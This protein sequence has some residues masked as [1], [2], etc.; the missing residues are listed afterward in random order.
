MPT[1]SCLRT[2]LSLL[3]AAVLAAGMTQPAGAA[4]TAQWED[5]AGADV[6]AELTAGTYIVTFVEEPAATY[7][8]SM[9]GYS[10]TAPAE[11]NQL[12][13]NAPAVKKYMRWLESRNKST[14][15]EVGARPDDVHSV[16]LNGATVD[17]TARQA[18]ELAKDPRVRAM[19]KNRLVTLDTDESPAALGLPALW[20]DL[21]GRSNAG[22][23]EVVGVLDSGI[24]P[25]SQ[26]FSPNSTPIPN[27]FTGTCQTGEQFTVADCNGKIVGARYYVEGFGKDNVADED[28]LSPRDGDGHGTHTASTAAG[29]TVRNVYVDD[30]RFG[31]ISGVAPGAKIAAYK[32]CWEG[33][34]GVAATGCATADI[35]NALNDAVG[36]GV[37]VINMSIGG[38][39]ESP[40]SDAWEIASL[41]AASAGV[42]V[43]TSAGNSGPGASTLD[44]PS[45]WVTTVAASTHKVNEQVLELADGR[46]FVG[47]S[48]TGPL[49]KLTGMVLAEDAAADDKEQAKLCLPDSLDP[50]LTRGKLVVCIR[51]QNPR[52]EKSLT[53]RKAGGVGMA[54]INPSA[55]S[56]N[57]DM[58]YVPSVHLP[59]SAYE[60]VTEYVTTS[61]QPRGRIVPLN[62]GESKTQTPEV[63]EFSSRGPSTTTGGDILKPDLSAPGVDV[64]AAVTPFNHEGRNYDLQSGTS[65]SAPHVAGVAAL[66][67]QAQPTWSPMMTKSAM[68]TTAR[69]HVSTADPFAQGAGFIR[70][71][72]ATDPGLVFDHGI[73]N[74]VGYLKGEGLLP[75]DS[76]TT[77]E[78]IDGSELNQASIAV[79]DLSSARMVTRTVTS[80]SDRPE[81]YR[82]AADVPGF[83]VTATPSQFTIKP[84]QTQTVSIL[85]ER[86]NAALEEWATGSVVFSSASGPERF[87]G[88]ATPRRGHIVQVP[89]ALRP[90]TLDINPEDVTGATPAGSVEVTVS[91]GYSGDVETSVAGLVGITPQQRRIAQGPIDPAAP[92]PGEATVEHVVQVPDD[93]AVWRLSTDAPDNVDVDVFIYVE[94]D[95]GL[96]L[97]AVVGT[98][99]GDELFTA[100]KPPPGTYH[101][102]VNGFTVPASGAEYT[103]RSWVVPQQ[104]AGNL[105]VDPAS[106]QVSSGVPTS[107][108]LAWSGLDPAEE[109]FGQ[110][111]F[112]APGRDPAATAYVTAK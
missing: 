33:K 36:D 43:A 29:N 12:D 58:H 82:F 32:V 76:Y 108:R 112:G 55:N 72:V 103:Y 83:R 1:R 84:G 90:K 26:S 25:E 81:R 97:A 64:L 8:G 101:V 16:A 47:A 102:F 10:A 98:S 75:A 79:G 92:E 65:M 54:L 106:R 27:S 109:W 104:S 78:P 95:D 56:L 3:T 52:V 6:P 53:V 110:V 31:T 17:L 86:T 24:W 91:P 107:M 18:L 74:W 13:V 66:L 69:D 63:A 77:I 20:D 11:G 37:D 39:S 34:L 9:A 48:S 111:S 40:I 71:P 88:D 51:G 96:A 5:S 94:T 49:R 4:D 87:A 61:S 46:R 2:T 100:A 67:R 45:P 85:F 42:F 22:S 80:V 28:Y 41:N 70:P 89:V 68:M 62:K 15:R 99:S 73:R 93:T 50:A 59:D 14:L 57:G 30:Q 35:V 21:G 7:S 44:H 23:G 38:S 19:E 60:P 105:T